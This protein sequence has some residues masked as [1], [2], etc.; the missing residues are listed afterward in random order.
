M[1]FTL[2]LAVL[3]CAAAMTGCAPAVAIHP[4]YTTQDLVSDLPLEGTWT[5]KDGELWQIGKFGDGYDVAAVH[6][7]DSI[8][9]S[10]YSVHLLRLKDAEFVDIAS[11]SD[12]EIGVAGHLFARVR[13]QG[14]ELYVSLIDELYVSLID[15]SWLKQMVEAGLAPQSTIGEGRQIVLTAPTSELQKFISLHAADPAAWN[16]DEEGLHRVR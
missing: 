13:M 12:P 5:V 16:D 15:D 2:W 4:L 11:K 1:R 3:A 14:D 8:D 10:K 9:V 6:T 7:G